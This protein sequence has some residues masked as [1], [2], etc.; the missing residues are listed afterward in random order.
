MIAAGYTARRTE[1]DAIRPRAVLTGALMGD[2]IGDRLERDRAARIRLGIISED[3]PVLA[4]QLLAI[5]RAL[6]AGPLTLAE[7]HEAADLCRTTAAK[8]SREAVALG[9]VARQ[10]KGTFTYRLTR[11]GREALEAQ[12]Q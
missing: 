3:A 9:L 10:E 12:P 5:L 7:M 1:R 6:A 11:E 4:P 8:R 2:P